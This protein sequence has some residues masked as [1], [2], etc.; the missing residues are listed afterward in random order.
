ML[1]GQG[2]TIKA[3]EAQ[4]DRLMMCGVQGLVDDMGVSERSQLPS[5]N[6]AKEKDVNALKQKV[7][8]LQDRLMAIDPASD[9]E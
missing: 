4:I 1:K 8:E 9:G 3:K 2:K 7:E 6:E 5:Q